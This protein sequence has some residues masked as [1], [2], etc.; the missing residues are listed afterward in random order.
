MFLS[1]MFL[2]LIKAVFK[3]QMPNLRR[4]IELWG[5]R[6]RLGLGRE[7]IPKGWTGLLWS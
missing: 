6:K 5:L 1:T 7:V 4:G 3:C 2:I